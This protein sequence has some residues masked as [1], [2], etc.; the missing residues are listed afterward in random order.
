MAYGFIPE[1]TQRMEAPTDRK[2]LTIADSIGRDSVSSRLQ[3]R[4]A[5][6]S[7]LVF[8]VRGSNL[9][10]GPKHR[11]KFLKFAGECRFAHCV[12]S[13]EHGDFFDPAGPNFL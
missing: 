13:K 1:E 8:G 10:G 5:K 12:D 9:A 4:R 3:P 11:P 2:I 7:V 6:T